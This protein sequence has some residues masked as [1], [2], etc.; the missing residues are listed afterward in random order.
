MAVPSANPVDVAENVVVQ[1]RPLVGLD[2]TRVERVR[3]EY[4]F[5]LC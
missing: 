4:L 1:Y 2:I 3:V 5:W